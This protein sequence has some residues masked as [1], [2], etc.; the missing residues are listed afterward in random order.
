M[1]HGQPIIKTYNTHSVTRR[2]VPTTSSP[3]H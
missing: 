1:M 3:V 2:T